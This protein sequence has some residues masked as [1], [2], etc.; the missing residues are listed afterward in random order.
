MSI[1]G[2]QRPGKAGAGGGAA[3]GPPNL[4][5]A[6]GGWLVLVIVAVFIGGAVG[7]VTMTQA[8][9]GTG[10]SGQAAWLLANAGIKDPATELVMVHGAAGMGAS[11]TLQ[12]AVSG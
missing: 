10:E 3:T 7:Q 12:V 5:A 8:E 9:Y 11:S 2:I 4:A 1:A 6:L